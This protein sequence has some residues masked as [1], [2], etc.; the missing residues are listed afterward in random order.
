MPNYRYY[1][2][3][4]AFLDSDTLSGLGETNR[5]PSGYWHNSFSELKK[6]NPYSLKFNKLPN[7]QLENI[8]EFLVTMFHWK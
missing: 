8:K 6:K 1:N 4:L 2:V 7:S 5:A 3:T